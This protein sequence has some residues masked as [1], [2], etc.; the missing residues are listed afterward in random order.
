MAIA[1]LTL[2]QDSMTI[3]AKDTLIPC[4]IKNGWIFY[5]TLNP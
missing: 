1:S 5:D 2:S 4:L 3:L